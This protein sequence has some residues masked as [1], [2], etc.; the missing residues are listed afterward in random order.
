MGQAEHLKTGLAPPTGSICFSVTEQGLRDPKSESLLPHPLR[1]GQ[2]DHLG[3]PILLDR[4]ENPVAPSV[5][6]NQEVQW[7]VGKVR[8]RTDTGSL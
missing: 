1:A 2:E 7:H 3:Q 8:C 5:V 6:P 4:P